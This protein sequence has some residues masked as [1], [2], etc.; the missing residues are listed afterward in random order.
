MLARQ[1][2][3]M[4]I[5]CCSPGLVKTDIFIP[6]ASNMNTSL[7]E[8]W[9]KFGAIDVNDS[10]VSTERLLFHDIESGCY[11]GSDGLRSPMASYRKPGSPEYDGSNGR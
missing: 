2:K 8:L 4:K 1:N 6:I 9:N 3:D 11:Y 7:E 5:V 10:T